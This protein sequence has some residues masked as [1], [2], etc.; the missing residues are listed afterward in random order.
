MT[1]TK[2]QTKMEE[3]TG[4]QSFVKIGK[5]DD[6]F[7]ELP[8]EKD[9]TVLLSTVQ[10]QYPNAIGLKYKSSSGGWRGIRAETNVLDPPAGGWGEGVYVITE[11][12]VLKRKASEDGGE[13]DR[14]S[15]KASKLLDDLIVLGLPYTTTEDELRDYF[16]ESCGEVSFCELKVDRNTNKSRGFGFIRFSNVDA[17]Q[18]AINR[19]HEIGGRKLNVR[20]SKSHDEVPMKLFVG[21]LAQGTTQKDV[22]EHFSEFGELTDVFVPSNPFRGFGFITYGDQEDAKKV[23]RMSHNLAGAHLN[24]VAAEERREGRPGNMNTN[25]PF[26]QNPSF[27][28][29]SGRNQ[30]FGQNS[31]YSSFQQQQPQQQQPVQKDTVS[32]LKDML[33]T[34]INSRK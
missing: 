16:T 11:S 1:K 6:D 13:D 4:Y 5:S 19:H 20:T 21:R 32:E 26:G 2:K 34:L 14:K 10:A 28:Q 9:G 33:V 18:E 22:D 27:G 7:M 17:A 25:Q 23:L 3:E 31:G 24:V 15:R 8:R 12:A 29:N 30:S